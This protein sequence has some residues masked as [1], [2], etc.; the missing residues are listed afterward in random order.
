MFEYY[1]WSSLRYEIWE[2]NNCGLN[3]SIL[4]VSILNADELWEDHLGNCV[5]YTLHIIPSGWIHLS[6]YLFT[7]LLLLHY[8]SILIIINLLHFSVSTNM[9]T[10]PF[11]KINY[12][13]L[14]LC[15][16]LLL[17]LMRFPLMIVYSFG[18]LLLHSVLLILKKFK[19]KEWIETWWTVTGREW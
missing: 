8:T 4:N 13:Y 12:N 6:S 14:L 17:L 2:R 5:L 16:L 3:V 18:F 19:R 10:Y 1:D 7:V 15:L 9:N 11:I